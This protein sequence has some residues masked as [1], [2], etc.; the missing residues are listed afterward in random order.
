MQGI[1]SLLITIVLLASAFSF[2]ASKAQAAGIITFA[3]GRFVWGKGVVFVFG[4]SEIKNKD[5]KGANIFKMCRN[6]NE[7]V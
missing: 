4:A 1:F 2:G 5:L 3:D 7:Q 6:I